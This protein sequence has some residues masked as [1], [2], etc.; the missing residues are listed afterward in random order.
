M[1]LVKTGVTAAALGVT[2]YSSLLG[3]RMSEQ[4][5]VPVTSGTRP[6]VRTPG[7][8]ARAQRQLTML[9]WAVP[10]LT[11]AL[12]VIRAFAGV[13]QRPPQVAEGI[14]ARLGRTG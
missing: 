5:D 14:G 7:E 3:K 2:A 1:A 9:Q 6:V 8:V 12:V 10:A 11:G 13:Q 4:H